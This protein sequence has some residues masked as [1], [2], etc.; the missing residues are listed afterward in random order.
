M[1]KAISIHQAC[2]NCGSS[3]A[4]AI[5]EGGTSFCFSCGKWTGEGHQKEKIKKLD[6]TT[7]HRLKDRGISEDTCRKYGVSVA[8]ED[9]KIIAHRYPY[10]DESGNEI[11]AKVRQLPKSFYAEGSLPKAGLFG[12]QLFPAGS[13]KAITITEGELDALSVYQ[14]QGS[15]WPVVSLKSGA[16]SAASDIKSNL[17][18]LEGFER[19]YLCFDADEAGADAAIKAAQ[20][21]SPGKAYIVRLDKA[22]KDSNGYLVANRGEDF[23]K[24]WWNAKQY[25]PDGILAAPDLIDLIRN[26]KEVPSVKYPWDSLNAL[27]YGL[28]RSEAVVVTA[29]TG[30]GK[31]LFL[32]QIYHNILKT[33]PEAKVGTL[34]LEE[35][36][37]DSGLGLMSIEAGIPFHLP[38]AKYSDAEYERAEGILKEGRSYYYDSFGSTSIDNIVNRV[39]YL[40][41]GLDCK[42]IFLDHLTMIV[43][44]QS[45]GDERKALDEI[46]T[47]LKKLTIELDM[48][49]VCVV[50]LNRQG[51]IR[52]TASIEQLA[53]IVIRLERD[54]THF[55]ETIRNQT[56]VIVEK[57]RFS[58]FTGPAG[59]LNYNTKTGLLSEGSLPE[60]EKLNADFSS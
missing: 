1:N 55:D 31:T 5:Y 56:N 21:L 23:I 24:T 36:P 50:H 16:A 30:V 25:T 26:R 41:K 54:K 18:Y 2:P 29:E 17:E 45:N 51:Q 20:V 19:V 38:D 15:R 10:H 8:V 49:L 13:A 46:M 37:V 32:R 3:D 58:G 12:S 47:K 14:L 22:L 27:T 60:Q 48:A 11:G 33:D 9:H 6:N 34:F 53:N 28:R 40:A 7:F 4:R 42:Y 44:D 57:N 35:T 52:N 59:V 39:R 43:S